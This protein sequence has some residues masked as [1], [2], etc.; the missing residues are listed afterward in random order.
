MEYT[1]ILEETEEGNYK[2]R[3]E[4]DLG[5]DCLY[6]HLCFDCWEPYNG[7][8]CPKCGTTEFERQV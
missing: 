4:E 6:E 5:V 1:L 8:G 7:T 3:W 2:M